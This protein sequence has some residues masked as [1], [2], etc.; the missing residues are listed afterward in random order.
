MGVSVG[1]LVGDYGSVFRLYGR[2]PWECVGC[3][4]GDYGG[5]SRLSGRRLWEYQ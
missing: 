4:V 3:L 1:C 2:R 5:V